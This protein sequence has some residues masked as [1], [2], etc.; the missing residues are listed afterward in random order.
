MEHYLK[1]LP[2]QSQLDAIYK[3][4]EAYLRAF[5]ARDRVLLIVN[6]PAGNRFLAL[7][8]I[9]VAAPPAGK[10]SGKPTGTVL[11]NGR[12][13]AGGAIPYGS[14]RRRR[15]RPSRSSSSASSLSNAVTSAT[16]CAPC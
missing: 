14:R 11:L 15:R 16:S 2:H 3:T 8:S 10:A 1:N 12:P 5:T 6:A 9:A 13:F 4:I 7:A